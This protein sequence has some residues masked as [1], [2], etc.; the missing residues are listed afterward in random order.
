MSESN[1]KV[2]VIVPCHNAADYLKDALESLLS[3][4]P[5]PWEVIVVDDGS[6]D[7]SAAIA[8]SFGPPVHCHRQHN[9][10]IAATRN[11]GLSLAKGEL[12]AFLDA[13]DLWPEGSLATR[14]QKLAEDPRLDGVFGQVEAFASPELS[15]EERSRLHVPVG[16]LAGR[17]AGAML[18]QRK[19][20]ERVGGFD[21][22]FTVGE[23]MDWVAR[24]EESGI[25]LGQL[26]QV[27]VRRRI[28]STNTVRKAESLK[29]DYLRLLRASLARRRTGEVSTNEGP[30]P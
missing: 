5:P 19:A 22:G 12:L 17:V 21:I 15:A 7:A 1:P 27:V 16:V 30:P 29:S 6:S 9:Q 8:E 4:Q 3:Q 2:S 18:L 14:L 26:D 23:T 25:V 11:K 10:G 13:D 20:F 28:H 24:A